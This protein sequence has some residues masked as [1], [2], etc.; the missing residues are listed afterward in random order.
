MT[1]ERAVEQAG[2]VVAVVGAAAATVTVRRPERVSER[3]ID[4]A[5]NDGIRRRCV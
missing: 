1:G 5:N 3:S 2:V 4:R